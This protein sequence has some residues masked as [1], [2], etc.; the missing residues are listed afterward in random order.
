[1]TKAE[2]EA[3]KHKTSIEDIDPKC[4]QC[5]FKELDITFIKEETWAYECPD[6]GMRQEMYYDNE[7]QTVIK[8]ILESESYKKVMK[9]V[10]E[11]LS[12]EDKKLFSNK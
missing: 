4:F 5:G 12:D 8:G 10:E 3:L 6:C 1:M 7:V 11:G 2:V 9:E